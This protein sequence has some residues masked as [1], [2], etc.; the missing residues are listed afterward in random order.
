MNARWA[1]AR[2]SWRKGLLPALVAGCLAACTV[3]DPAS[4][5]RSSV[6]PTVASSSATPTRSTSPTRAHP[7]RQ[8]IRHVCSP[9]DFRL[10]PES[11]PS[12]GSVLLIG[13]VHLIAKEPCW[14]RGTYKVTVLD[15]EGRV[16]AMPHNPNAANRLSGPLRPNHQVVFTTR[17]LQPFCGRADPY[18][19]TFSF[20][21]AS[22]HSLV[23]VRSAMRGVPPPKCPTA[24]GGHTQK[25][26]GLRFGGVRTYDTKG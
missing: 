1:D 8:L 23:P 12:T 13:N 20:T 18:T 9:R 4:V 25:P 11:D 10:R 19:V 2:A 6:S 15:R 22:R 26:A 14:L 16:V 24:Y 17:W 7:K 5:A 21:G 3:S